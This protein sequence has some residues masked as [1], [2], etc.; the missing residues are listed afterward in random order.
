M[1][2]P[3]AGGSSRTLLCSGSAQSRTYPRIVKPLA[4]R[5]TAT[6]ALVAVAPLLALVAA[7]IRWD[8]GGPALFRQWR[9]GRDGRA[10]QVLK[11]RSMPLEVDPGLPSGAAGNVATTRIGRILRRTNM[12]E[13]PQMV[14]IL[15][16]EM[17]FI[18]PRP[19]LPSQTDLLRLRR[20]NGA[21]HLAPGLTGLAQVNAF[22]GMSEAEKAELDGL[23][24]ERVGP[25]TDLEILVRTVWYLRQPPPAY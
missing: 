6:V 8:D 14:N 17:S 21:A 9:V 12:D 20:S 5:V 15:R 7:A 19:A 25:A 22:D 1:T 3:V 24:A 18:G 4:D 16:G 13:L 10:F 11:F 2:V 23:Y